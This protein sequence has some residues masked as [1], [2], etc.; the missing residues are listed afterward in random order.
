MPEAVAFATKPEIAL[1]QIGAAVAAGV[2][3]GVVLMDAGYGADTKLRTAITALGLRYVAGI[4]PR[5]T[6]WPRGQ[7][8]LPPKP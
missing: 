4:Q 7:G 6:V 2:P 1:A 5:T 3:Q 8:P